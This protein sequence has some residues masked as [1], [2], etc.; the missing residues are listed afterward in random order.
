M[1]RR[2]APIV[3][4]AN[5]TAINGLDGDNNG[6]LFSVN[7]ILGYLGGNGGDACGNGVIGCQCTYDLMYTMISDTQ[8]TA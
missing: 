3:R 4:N 8:I 6:G 7:G 1:N 2:A 5:D